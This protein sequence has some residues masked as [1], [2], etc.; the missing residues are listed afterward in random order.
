MPKTKEQKEQIVA[1]LTDKLQK[2][3]SAVFT[4]ISGY[5]MEDANELQQTAKENDLEVIIAKKTLLEIAVKNAGIQGLNP[6]ELEGSILTTFGYSD[7]IAPARIMAKFAKGRVGL[8]MLAGVLEGKGVDATMVKSLS[9]LPS[10]DEL[11]AKLVGSI[12]APVS[13]FVGVLN[14]NL[15]NLVGVINAI[16]ESKV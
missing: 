13:G 14:A 16:K 11:L 4:Q 1:D 3:K 10:R 7:E 8:Q 6:S 12:N 15:R 5:T 9:V 2:S